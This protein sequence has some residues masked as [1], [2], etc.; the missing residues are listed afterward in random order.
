[1]PRNSGTYAIHIM[2]DRQS[3]KSG[4][5]YIEFPSASAVALVMNSRK[6]THQSDGKVYRNISDRRV[7]LEP[8]THEELMREVFPK[9]KCVTWYGQEPVIHPPND[10]YTSGF[11]E[12]V[13]SEE[14]VLTNRWANEPHKSK[15]TGTHPQRPY[16]SLITLLFKVSLLSSTTTNMNRP[17]LPPSFQH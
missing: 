14:L 11:A 17:F 2:F 12:F 13:T 9:A 5:C 4:D 16:E 10:I 15:Y 3:A 7:Y 1:M 8:S 6:N